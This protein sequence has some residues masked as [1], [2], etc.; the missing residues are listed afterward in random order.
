MQYKYI[1][2]LYRHKEEKKMDQK[3]LNDAFLNS[4]LPQFTNKSDFTKSDIQTIKTQLHNFANYYAI[5]FV[6]SDTY[7][8]LKDFVNN[9]CVACRWYSLIIK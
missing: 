8:V 6:K 7:K 5:S 3:K 9:Y 2:L 1:V 4:G